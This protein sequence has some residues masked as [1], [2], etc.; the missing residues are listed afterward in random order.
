M[1]RRTHEA[2]AELIETVDDLEELV[3]DKRKSWRA[4]SSKARRRQRRYKNRLTNE[5]IRLDFEL[6]D[7]CD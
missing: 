5:L 1:A 6:I 2:D 7:N 4:N 3:Q